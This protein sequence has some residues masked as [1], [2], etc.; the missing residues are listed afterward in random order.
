[1]TDTGTE[2]VGSTM[3]VCPECKR[4]KKRHQCKFF[5]VIGCVL[6]ISGFTV[7]FLL[8]V[9]F[10]LLTG[11]HGLFSAFFGTH[12]RFQLLDTWRPWLVRTPSVGG[13]VARILLWPAQDDGEQSPGQEIMERCLTKPERL[14]CY[15]AT[16]KGYLEVADAIVFDASR[17]KSYVFPERRHPSQLWVFSTQQIGL[18]HTLDV[19][20]NITDLFNLTMTLRADGD[21]VIP[22]G[23]WTTEGVEHSPSRKRLLTALKSKS[24]TA[25]LF[26]SDCEADTRNGSYKI[27]AAG[28]KRSSEL[29]LRYVCSHSE[30]T[31]FTG[32]GRPL[33]GSRKECL[34]MVAQDYYFIFVFETSPCFQNPV[35]LIYDSFNYDIVPAYFGKPPGLG[36]LV[37]PGS[38]Y[39]T[40]DEKTAAHIS[41]KLNS[42]RA[43]TESYLQYLLWKDVTNITAPEDV[44][45]RLCDAAYLDWEHGDV[46]YDDIV[47]WWKQ[48]TDCTDVPAITGGPND[49]VFRPLYPGGVPLPSAPYPDSY[50]TR[51]KL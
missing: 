42:L 34:E 24:R 51:N 15:I 43:D 47:A 9:Y 46:V 21:V 36:S 48:R 20:A 41:D 44:L 6:F 19:F 8:E 50:N 33:C 3:P 31:V 32:C 40:T 30:V 11:D 28:R 13:P 1:M 18:D 12:E 17:L 5:F 25:A 37:P 16:H 26:V 35:E 39:D 38:V 7:S 2:R 22:Y 23:N 14:P 29:Y 45:C 4:R 10:G 49:P 27:N